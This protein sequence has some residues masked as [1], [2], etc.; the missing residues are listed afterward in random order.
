MK[1]FWK[2]FC[3]AILM[4]TMAYEAN[5]VFYSKPVFINIPGVNT[6]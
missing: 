3:V 5:V 1:T 2:W 4:F 6:N